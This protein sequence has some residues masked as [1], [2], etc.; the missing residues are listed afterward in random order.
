MVIFSLFPY[1]LPNPA[2]PSHTQLCVF[3]LCPIKF[4]L[5]CLTALVHGACPRVW[6]PYQGHSVKEHL[7][8]LSPSN[9]QMPVTTQLVVG[10]TALC[11]GLSLYK[12]CTLCPNLCEFT[13]ALSCFVQN[14]ISLMSSI[15]SLLQSFLRYSRTVF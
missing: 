11:R 15:I 3:F 2:S 7:L 10:F 12:S 8:S 1:F 5:C 6:S 14:K 4:S 9:Y 13:Y